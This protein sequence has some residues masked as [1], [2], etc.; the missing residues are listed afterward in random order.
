M[1]KGLWAREAAPETPEELK[2]HVKACKLKTCPC[3]TLGHKFAVSQSQ[4]PLVTPA[5]LKLLPPDSVEAIKAAM[6][7]LEERTSWLDWH[8]SSDGRC[9]FGCRL[10]AETAGF[11]FTTRDQCKQSKLERHADNEQHKKNVCRA[12]GFEPP[13]DSEEKPVVAP[14]KATFQEVFQRLQ[15]NTCD[16]FMDGVA[17]EDKINKIQFTIVETARASWRRALAE[18]VSISLLRDE[19]HK[20]VLLCFRSADASGNIT[21]GVV[22]QLKMSFSSTALG[23]AE[24]THRLLREFCTPGTGVPR[25]HRGGEMVCDETLLQHVRAHVHSTCVDAASNEVCATF[26]TAAA[27]ALPLEGLPPG[28]ALFPNHQLVVR[29][30]AHGSR[31]I[32]SRPWTADRYLNS[33]FQS[34]V[35]GPSS[36]VQL[37]RHSMDFSQWYREAT[38]QSLSKGNSFALAVICASRAKL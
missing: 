33:L 13:A 2:Q 26:D 7:A 22:G 15:K 36:L 5:I 27:W 8:I 3:H 16:R 25:R 29:D 38:A 20:R 19:R 24:A 9:T 17:A 37:I 11:Q 10:C 31:R 21:E 30:R 18:A 23:L 35:S 34:L 4:C 14:S 32:L 28:E 1:A 12:L 6:H